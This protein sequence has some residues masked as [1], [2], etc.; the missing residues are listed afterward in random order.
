MTLQDSRAAADGAPHNRLRRIEF[1][2]H[3]GILRALARKHEHVGT[4]RARDRRKQVR[5]IA[6]AGNRTH[7]VVAADDQC[8]AMTKSATADM[9]G[10]GYVRKIKIWMR[11]EMVSEPL[12]DAIERPRAAR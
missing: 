4:R 8:T 12:A 6:Q 11:V 2:R 10:E 9:Q 7:S 3:A 5:D 1:G